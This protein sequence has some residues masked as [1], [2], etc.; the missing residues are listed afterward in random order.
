MLNLVC[1]ALKTLHNYNKM[2][3]GWFG[4]FFEI[5]QMQLSHPQSSF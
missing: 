5:F 4:G 3:F 2:L 1:M